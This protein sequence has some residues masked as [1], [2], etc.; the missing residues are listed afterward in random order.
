MSYQEIEA[1]T[2]GK[3]YEEIKEKYLFVDVRTPEEYQ[4]GHIPNAKINIPHDQLESRLEELEGYE[5]QP[6]LLICRSGVR[7]LIAADF[8]AKKGFSKLYNLKGGMLEWTGP[9]EC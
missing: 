3:K 6:I 8:L 9:I 5:N 4:E 1:G 2:L 7:S